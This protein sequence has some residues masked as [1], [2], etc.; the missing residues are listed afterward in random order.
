MWYYY[1]LAHQHKAAG[2]KIKLSKNDHDRVSEGI[3]IMNE[4]DWSIINPKTAR[5]LCN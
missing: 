3:I 1:F 5:T 2:V 4:Y